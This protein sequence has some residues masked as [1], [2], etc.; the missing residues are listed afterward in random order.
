MA[1]EN[2]KMIQTSWLGSCWDNHDFH[3]LEHRERN[4][5]SGQTG[6]V[7]HV[8]TLASAGRWVA[9]MRMLG[10]GVANTS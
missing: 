8:V 5:V 10:R 9:G 7:L 2:L 1:Y 3:E 4:H 6:D